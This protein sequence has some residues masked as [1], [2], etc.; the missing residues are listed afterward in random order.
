M[1][2][3]HAGCTSFEEVRRLTEMM[4]LLYYSELGD[5]EMA[6]AARSAVRGITYVSHEGHAQDVPRIR[7]SPTRR[8]VELSRLFA[9]AFLE[10]QHLVKLLHIG[11]V[12]LLPQPADVFSGTLLHDL[13]TLDS[14]LCVETLVRSV[15][16]SA[17]HTPSAPATS[18]TNAM[19]CIMSTIT[20][21][22]NQFQSGFK[23]FQYRQADH[24]VT[25][26]AASAP[27]METPD[28]AMDSL[29]SGGCGTKHVRALLARPGLPG[30]SDLSVTPPQHPT[31]TAGTT[32]L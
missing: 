24:Y 21:L 22:C 29:E 28:E 30:A 3:V 11:N 25:L 12:L 9:A 2:V 26:T 7:S 27:R 16:L 20:T 5:E 31:P 13:M 8:T 1:W 32:T 6:S 19:G 15:A 18:V 23:T 14:P 17:R 4:V 10:V